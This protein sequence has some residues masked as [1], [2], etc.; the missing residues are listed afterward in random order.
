MFAC[1]GPALEIFSRYRAV[2]TADGRVVGLAEYLEKVWEVVGRT[3]LE[4]VLGVAEAEARNGLAGALEEDARLTALFLW[5]L[6]ATTG[7][8]THE[9][10][11]QDADT[12]GENTDEDAESASAGKGFSLAFDVVRRFAQPLGIDLKKWERRTIETK[13][14]VVRLLPVA[15]RATRLFGEHGS[16]AV[17]ARLEQEAGAGTDPLQGASCETRDRP[18]FP[19]PEAAGRGTVSGRDAAFAGWQ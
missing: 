9:V 18:S 17:A 1:I 11:A 16:Q 8:E 4:S 5:T 3:A 15:E 10:G 2:E 14:G 7:D 12:P 19:L 6:Q 13:K